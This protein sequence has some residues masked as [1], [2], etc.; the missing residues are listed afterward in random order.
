MSS[1]ASTS[2]SDNFEQNP[3]PAPGDEV[4]TEVVGGEALVGAPAEL[5]VVEVV[6]VL[7]E[8]EAVVLVCLLAFESESELP[9]AAANAERTSTAVIA[10]RVDPGLPML[11]MHR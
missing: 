5:D 10:R 1:T 6:D 11:C 9:H 4:A 3:P 8:L 2:A 7:D